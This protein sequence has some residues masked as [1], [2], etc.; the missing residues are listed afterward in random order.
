MVKL[1]TL[2][3][4]K[5]Q[6]HRE[7]LGVMRNV[8]H[9]YQK[10]A[11]VS[12]ENLAVMLEHR[13]AL[14]AGRRAYSSIR[15]EYRVVNAQLI[16]QMRLLRSV[17]GIGRTVMYMWQAHSI[18][19]IRV[20]DAQARYADSQEEVARLEEIRAHY[21][22][23]LGEKSVYYQDLTEKLTR[24]RKREAD[25]LKEV[26]RAQRDN[27][28]GYAGMT[29]RAVE[30]IPQLHMIYYRLKIISD[31]GKAGAGGG[32]GALLTGAAGMARGAAGVAAGKVGAAAGAGA[33]GAGAAA[34]M[35]LPFIRYAI[36]PER[37]RE[38]M[39]MEAYVQ[40][41]QAA[42]VMLTGEIPQGI[43]D[44]KNT[45]IS[46][47]NIQENIP[48]DMMEAQSSLY[49]IETGAGETAEHTKETVEEVKGLATLWKDFK[50]PKFK[51]PKFEWPEFEW[52]KFEWPFRDGAAADG[53]TP[54]VPP[55]PPYVDRIINA[56]PSI[57]DFIEDVGETVSGL[58][59][60]GP[61]F[62][63][64]KDVME[65]MVGQ[66]P[67]PDGKL[68]PNIEQAEINI[69]QNFG[70]VHGVKDIEEA[71]YEAAER[72]REMLMGGARR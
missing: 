26:N 48:R 54:F 33:A 39:R 7:T 68:G 31:L 47:K 57:G 32:F 16:E 58:P 34:F 14:L 50:W 35:T 60:T 9:E 23:V 12:K 13:R 63:D 21:A 1:S 42:T 2:I 69:N 62:P 72:I 43:S 46:M 71:S 3:D 11:T 22:D 17:S 4:Y 40:Q 51:W 5:V 59:V 27:M 28:I 49:G 41:S 15:M 44:M 6:G 25:A 70:D 38:E 18:A 10:H 24:T 45:L 56:L 66:I 29:L 64:Y 8:L 65:M 61:V 55:Q 52:P 36:T 67:F 20:A 30:L 19:Q 53:V 37:E